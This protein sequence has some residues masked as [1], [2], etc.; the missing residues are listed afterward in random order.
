MV[1]TGFNP[2]SPTFM[3][4]DL[5]SCFATVEQQANP[6]LR[7][8]PI[9]VAAYTTDGGC[10]LAPSVEAKRRG[11]KTGMRVGEGKLLCPGLIILPSD[12]PKYRFVNRKLRTLLEEYTDRVEVKS[13][14]EMVLDFR[15]TPEFAM[16]N[17]QC[18]MTDE[19]I[20]NKM[21]HTG[22]EIKQRIR[23]EIG[24]WLTVSVGIAPNRY[25]A[26]TASGLRKPDGLD[27][28][29]QK[30]IEE[31]LSKM[32]IED[33]CGIKDGYGRRL[34]CYGIT[35]ALTMYQAPSAV[36]KKAFA[37]IIGYHWWMRL[38]GWEVDDREFATK[39]IGHSYALYKPYTREDQPLLQILC[40]LVE[41]VGRRLRSHGYRARGIH[42][43]CY[44]RDN[45]SWNHG[46]TLPEALFASCDIY[47]AGVA[48][49]K[50]G[51]LKPIRVLAITAFELTNDVYGQLSL[52]PQEE[53]KAQLT[54]AL[55]ALDTRWGDF[56]VFPGRM[57]SMERRIVDRIAFGSVRDIPAL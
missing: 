42:I 30:N 35:T 31:I 56:T 38:H 6:L 19:E 27:A 54:K 29:T 45:T 24:E 16:P 34:R 32:Q 46:E 37:S 25:L 28:I 5:N 51:P 41:K 52:L 4:I 47:K 14:D 48:I 20:K 23:N 49:L 53:K 13:I 43:S 2:G 18:Q 33:L 9:A 8:K 10:I 50:K 39:S 3:H 44:F 21:L 36:L 1:T 12:P 7:G 40:Q 22:R 11:V 15:H 57:L 26:K 17:N 55:D